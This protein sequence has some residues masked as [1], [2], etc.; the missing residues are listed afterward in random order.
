MAKRPVFLSTDRPPYFREYPVEFTFYSGFAASQ[1]QKSVRSLHDAFL[2]LH[3]SEQVLEISGASEDNLGISLSAFHLGV[4]L[5]DG[6]NCTVETVFQS[7]KV[8]EQGGPYRDLLNKSSRDAKKD[9]RLKESG[10]L[11]AFDAMGRRFPLTP[12]TYFYNWLYI[13]ALHRHPELTEPLAKYTAFTDIAFNPERSLNCQ[14]CAA[15]IYVSLRR[16]GVLEEAL[17]DAESFLRVVYGQ[18]ES[19]T[20]DNVREQ[21]SFWE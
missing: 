3:P 4:T 5:T 12:Q 21:L 8:F 7:S 11:I 16:N 2:A 20:P 15:A 14:A 19:N 1:K 6:R 17:R 9:P 18:N 10:R 13:N